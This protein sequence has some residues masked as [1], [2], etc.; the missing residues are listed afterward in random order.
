MI[1]VDAE[2]R[3]WS[4][5]RGG[6]HGAGATPACDG[7]R[8]RGSGVRTHSSWYR[9]QKLVFLAWSRRSRFTYQG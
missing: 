8:L 6:G 2:I 7:E 9:D 4:R 3:Q 5:L 1:A